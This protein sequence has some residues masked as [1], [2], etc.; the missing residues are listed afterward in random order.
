MLRQSVALGA[1]ERAA[2]YSADMRREVAAQFYPDGFEWLEEA[3]LPLSLGFSSRLVRRMLARDP[4]P[5]ADPARCAAP[6]CSP[7]LALAG[8]ARAW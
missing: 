7:G 3:P 1:G 6:L 4:A 5:V 2:V 8:S